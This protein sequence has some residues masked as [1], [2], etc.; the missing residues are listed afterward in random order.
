MTEPFAAADP[1]QQRLDQ[2][3]RGRKWTA[4][5]IA[6]GGGLLTAGA[7]T[8]ASHSTSTASH[9][10]STAGV[11]DL[12]TV[13]TADIGSAVETL[14]PAVSSQ[15][16]A[17]A[18]SCNAPLAYVSIAKAPGSAGGNIRIISGSYVSPS[19]QL[20]DAPQRVAIPFPAPYPM[21]QGT[22]GIEA[23]SNGAIISL[24]PAWTV[25]A[26]NGSAIRNVIW[27]TGNPCQ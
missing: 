17:E 23:N 13:A 27:K 16:T 25:A 19:F 9:G 24:R 6:L 2:P 15:L 14:S 18:K 12:S 22:I 5:A 3:Q 4:A 10:A 8:L 7:L 26:I 1:K 11:S 20:T 21:G